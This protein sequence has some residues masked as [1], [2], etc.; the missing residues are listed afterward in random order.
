MIW[1][2]LVAQMVKNLPTK[3]EAQ[4]WPLSWEDPLDKRMTTHCSILA[5]RIPQTERQKG[6]VTTEAEIG[7][8]K[9]QAKAGRPRP[10]GV[11]RLRDTS[12]ADL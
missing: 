5:W 2:S 11:Q 6:H 4:V 1:A 9:L 3:Q 8:M 10:E 12:A 7:A